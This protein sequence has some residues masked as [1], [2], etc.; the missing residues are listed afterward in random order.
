[1]DDTRKDSIIFKPMGSAVA[2]HLSV[3][4][5]YTMI[6]RSGAYGMDGH[7]H[8]VAVIAVPFG[9]MGSDILLS[10]IKIHKQ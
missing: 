2:H 4:V 10:L 9:I 1:M 7:G 8:T 3:S 5:C 6:E